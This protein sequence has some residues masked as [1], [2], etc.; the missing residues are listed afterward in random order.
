MILSLFFTAQIQAKTVRATEMTSV[1]W[2]HL[3]GAGSDDFTIEF[4]QGD[5]LPVTVGAQGDF[6]ETTQVGTSE[7]LVKKNFWIQLQNN[8]LRV[9]LDGTTFK[10]MGDVVT[11]GLTV[12]GWSGSGPI[13]AINL[14]LEAYAK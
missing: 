7:V 11:G 2:S 4:R 9:S 3:T 1:M 8:A 6:L 14:A 5:V 13:N 10:P 12:G